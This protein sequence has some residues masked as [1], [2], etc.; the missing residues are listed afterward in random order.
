MVM[1]RVLLLVLIHAREAGHETESSSVGMVLVPVLEMLKVR[2][3]LL[4]C[5]K[6][7][8]DGMNCVHVQYCLLVLDG[9]DDSSN[10]FGDGNVGQVRYFRQI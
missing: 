2:V 10:C 1:L 3:T 5:R 6:V 8:A 4:S 9:V 7:C